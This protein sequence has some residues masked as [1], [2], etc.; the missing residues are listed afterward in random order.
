METIRIIRTKMEMNSSSSLI[1]KLH[2]PIPLQQQLLGKVANIASRKPN[3]SCEISDAFHSTI[4]EQWD[5]VIYVNKSPH[6]TT[7]TTTTIDMCSNTICNA[8]VSW[9][10][11][12]VMVAMWRMFAPHGLVLL[13]M[14]IN[15][16]LIFALQNNITFLLHRLFHSTAQYLIFYP[17]YPHFG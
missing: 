9:C 4:L 2:T 8:M 14:Q 11:N 16:W 3:H 7:T 12:R 17:H 15:I 6:A 1:D 13:F 10:V 5:I